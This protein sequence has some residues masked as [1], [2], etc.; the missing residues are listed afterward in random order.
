MSKTETTLCYSP[1]TG[2]VYWGK[3]NAE[4]G[5]AVGNQKKDVTN[6]FLQ[7]LEHKF[8]V[9]TCQKI[10]VNGKHHSTIYNIKSGREVLVF[11]PVDPEDIDHKLYGELADKFNLKFYDDHGCCYSCTQGVKEQCECKELHKI[12]TMVI[13]L[14]KKS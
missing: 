8:P 11:D 2:K 12:Q 10:T 6:A 7:V 4:T 9:N 5:I 1:L 14:C 3:V 13:N